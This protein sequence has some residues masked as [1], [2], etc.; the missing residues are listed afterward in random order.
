MKDNCLFCQIAH[1]KI[2]SLC[3][4]EDDLIMVILDAYPDS[5]GHT[6]IIPKKHY[7][8]IMT[9]DSAT[10]SHMLE[11]AQKFVS[12][13]MEKLNK[14]SMTLLFNYGDSQVIKHIHLHL[15]PNFKKDKAHLS[16]EE[17]Y[18]ILMEK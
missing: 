14:Q 13:L 3:L 4:Y 17:V 15:I 12:P 10:L 5:D 16:R 7:D 2:D 1:K 6:L 8:D 9:I 18:K 11:V